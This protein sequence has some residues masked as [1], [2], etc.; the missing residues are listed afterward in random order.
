MMKKVVELITK[1]TIEI[2][3]LPTCQGWVYEPEV[4]LMMNEKFLGTS[5]ITREDTRIRFA[6]Q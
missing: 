2:G 1:K 4:P 5:T 3:P 6:Q